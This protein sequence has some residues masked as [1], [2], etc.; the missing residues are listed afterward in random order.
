RVQQQ[1]VIQQHKPIEHEINLESTKHLTTKP[2]VKESTISDKNASSQLDTQQ[3]MVPESTAPTTEQPKQL[4]E[5]DDD[6]LDF[7]FSYGSTSVPSSPTK[8]RKSDMELMR[9]LVLEKQRRDEEIKREKEIDEQ[10]R[11]HLKQN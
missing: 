3:N 4:E 10:I 9:E 6:I 8:K 1:I 7:S 5:D 2:I 11:N